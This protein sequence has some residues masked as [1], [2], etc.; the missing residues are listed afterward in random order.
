MI[1]N[2]YKKEV[3]RDAKLLFLY[4]TANDQFGSNYLK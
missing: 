3:R 2:R 4:F 1:K